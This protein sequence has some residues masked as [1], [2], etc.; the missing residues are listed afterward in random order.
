MKLL[1]ANKQTSGS[2]RAIACQSAGNHRPLRN[3]YLCAKRFFRVI[4]INERV[5]CAEKKFCRGTKIS[6][7]YEHENGVSA[8]FRD[9]SPPFY[10]SHTF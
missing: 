3:A 5:A 6:R 1:G 9:S 7:T 10:S 4:F 8:A 2:Y